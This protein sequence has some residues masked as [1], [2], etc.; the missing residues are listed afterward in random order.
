MTEATQSPPVRARRSLCRSILLLL[1]SA[2]I[3][4]CGGA[5]GW[6]ARML[7]R[8]PPPPMMG[9][10]AEPPVRD[11]VERLKVELLLSDE[12]AQ[13]VDD[14]YRQRADALEK[15]RQTF[16]PQMRAEYDQLNEQMKQILNPEQFRLWHER[17]EN[18]RNRMLPPPPGRPPRAPGGPQGPGDMR[19]PGGP[20]GPGGPPGANGPPPMRGPGGPGPGG[21]GGGNGPG[22]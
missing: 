7:W 22:Q 2:I 10:G 21:M 15:I 14:I 19:G 8:R 17:F 9:I 1:L 20:M 4:L 11:M 16:E 12:Q 5:A 6:G 18:V 3:F 13:K